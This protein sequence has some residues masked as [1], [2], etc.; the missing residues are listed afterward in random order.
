MNA[1]YQEMESLKRKIVA[2]EADLEN[3]KQANDRDLVLMYGN[4]LLAST[5]LLNN[6]Y[7]KEQLLESSG[8]V[9]IL[10]LFT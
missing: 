7:Q 1:Q 8:I 4:L 5:N 6:L 10:I 9:F 3:A 2:T